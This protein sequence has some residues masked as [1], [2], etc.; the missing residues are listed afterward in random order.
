MIPTATKAAIVF[1][2]AF[3]AAPG[4]DVDGIREPVMGSLLSGNNIATAAIGLHFYPLWEAASMDEWLYNGGPYQLII[5][6]L[7]PSGLI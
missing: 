4:V 7:S 6:H 2:I 5:F 3:V 1:I